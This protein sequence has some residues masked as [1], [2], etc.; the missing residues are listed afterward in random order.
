MEK[1][2]GDGLMAPFNT[3]G[4]TPDHA[5]SAAGAA[6]VLQRELTRSPTPIEDGLGC[7]WASTALAVVREMGRD[8]LVAYVVVG[9]AVNTASR[10]EDEPPEGGV[11]MGTETLG[12]CPKRASSRRCRDCG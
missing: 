7:A 2:T 4:D 12:R 8:G 9:D 5:V 10:L 6:L 1:F 11:R 3:G